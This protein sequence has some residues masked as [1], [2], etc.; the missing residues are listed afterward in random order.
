MPLFRSGFRMVIF[1]VL[2]MVV[3]LF[4]QRGL[5]GSRE[6]TWDIL[7]P[8]HLEEMAETRKAREGSAMAENVL[9]IENLTMQFGGVVA[10]NNLNHGCEQRRDRRAYRPQRRGQDDGLQRGDRRVYAVPTAASPATARQIA[11][12]HP[13]RQDERSCT[14][15]STRANTQA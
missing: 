5:M 11:E 3:V 12:G 7:L 8:G 4:Y 10:V 2:L 6:F 9:R 14:P 15:A 1:S 13:A